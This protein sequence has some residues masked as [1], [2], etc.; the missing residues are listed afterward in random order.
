MALSFPSFT[1][2]NRLQLRTGRNPN[3]HQPAI[4]VTWRRSSVIRA[5]RVAISSITSC[6]SDA[7]PVAHQRP[8][9]ESGYA[10]SGEETRRL[11]TDRRPGIRTSSYDHEPERAATRTATRPSTCRR[12]R[13][14]ETGACRG[15]AARLGHHRCLVPAVWSNPSPGMHSRQDVPIIVLVLGWFSSGVPLSSFV[16]CSG[17]VSSCGCA[18]RNERRGL[19]RRAG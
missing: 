15:E 16:R 8:M 18:G 11:H 4:S 13:R 2:A 3:P 17:L 9:A 10:V 19:R 12:H 5:C 14:L 6:G 7:Q 1:R